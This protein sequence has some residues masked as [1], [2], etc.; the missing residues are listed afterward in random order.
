MQVFRHEKFRL[1]SQWW[2]HKISDYTLEISNKSTNYIYQHHMAVFFFYF[3]IWAGRRGEASV[4]GHPVHLFTKTMESDCANDLT[5]YN[6]LET[7]TIIIV[8]TISLLISL[9]SI[10]YQYYNMYDNSVYPL[11]ISKVADIRC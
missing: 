8:C 5:S 2:S 4:S 9:L 6:L 11:S 1:L 10:Q 7:V 3:P